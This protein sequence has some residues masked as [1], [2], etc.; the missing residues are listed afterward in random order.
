MLNAACVIAPGLNDEDKA[1]CNIFSSVTLLRNRIILTPFND[2][3]MMRLTAA[4]SFD[5]K[6]RRTLLSVAAILTAAAVPQAGIGGL[7][8]PGVSTTN[9]F[10]PGGIIPYEFDT[11]WPTTPAQRQTYLD[12]LREWELAANIRL[13]ARTSQTNYLRLRFAFQSTTN[14]FLLNP[15]EPPTLTVDSLQRNQLTHE[16]GHALGL[17]HEHVRA[18]RDGFIS[19]NTT[20]LDPNA[21]ALYAISSNAT[22]TGSYDFE[23]VMHYGRRLFAVDPNVDVITPKPAYFEKYYYRIGTLALSVGDRAAAAYLYGAPTNALTNV[24]TTTSDGGFG[25]L[26][27]AI[28][29]ANDHPGTTIRFNLSTNDPG[30]T[31]GVWTLQPTGEFPP[32]VADGT[33][34]DATTQ[35]G[36]TNH[37]IVALDGSTLLPE[38]YTSSGLHIYAAR[39]AVKGLAI[40]GFTY[41]GVL[42]EYSGATSNTLQGC[43]VGM[44]ATGMNPTPNLYH[45]ITLSLGANRNVIGGTN[46]L[47]RNVISGNLNYGILCSDTNTCGNVIQGNFIGLN[48][49]GDAVATNG[50]SGVGIVLGADTNTVG[51]GN[52]ISGNDYGVLIMDPNS[53]GNVV[54]GNFIGT[55][56]T[57]S[58]AL[59]NRYSGVGIFGQAK[60]TLVGGTNATARNVVSGNND[61]GVIVGDPGTDHTMIQGNYIG[62]DATGG[63]AVPNGT[64]IGLFRQSQFTTIGGDAPGAGNVI[65]G[66]TSDGVYIADPGTRSNFVAGNFI[67]TDRFG[68]NELPNQ[69]G[70]SIVAGPRF[71]LIGGTT[72][73]ARNVISGN[74]Y[75]AVYFAG[76][77]TASNAVTGNFIGTTANGHAALGNHAE[78][79]VLVAGAAFNVI[80]GDAAAARNVIAAGAYTGVYLAGAGTRGNV[81]QGNYIGTDATGTNALGHGNEGVAIFDGAQSNLIG[82]A[83][84]GE[85]NVI[86]ASAY[87][88]IF[89]ADTNTS[90]NLVQGNSIG[91]GADDTTP[92]PNGYE[93]V[94]IANGAGTNVIGL[95]LDGG[96]AGNRIAFNTFAGVY[97]GFY[98]EAG[99][100]GNVIR[101]NATYANGGLGIE[102]AGGTEDFNGVTANDGGDGDNGPNSLQNFPVITNAFCYPATTTIVGALNSTPNRAFL[103]DVYRNASADP[104]GYGEGQVYAGSAGLTTDGGGYGGFSLVNSG[105]LAGQVFTATA[106]DTITGDTSEFGPAMMATNAPP[107]PEFVAPVELTGTGFVASIS[108]A[109]GLNYRIQATTNLGT[110]PIPWMDLTN[111]VA[112]T[113]NYFFLDRGATNHPM[114]FYRVVSP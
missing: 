83:T 84:A 92:L 41:A 21:A 78:S 28:Y 108:L 88:G 42:L 25:S 33:V 18:D 100:R 11:N 99:T 96:G 90:G 51:P 113:T 114:R 107:P 75:N 61:Y 64:G 104:S 109:I 44:D 110:N 2:S 59:A 70:V 67:G 105:N 82:G 87:R 111:F 98:D 36:Y 30:Y 103:I 66:N 10:W 43:H 91:V 13:V 50:L 77:D 38:A 74:T 62:T 29:F 26:R 8:Y 35:P 93:G 47:Q 9:L 37:P 72:T 94:A 89:I 68:T 63:V 76:P 27:A 45:G 7:I 81:V 17:E 52:V 20:N 80:G 14:T 19:I 23:S 60:Y 1:A 6:A 40:G 55:D 79:I 49:A 106:T 48:A 112:G 73:A 56:A 85:G 34:I 31:N 46:A 24:V 4:F 5:H 69:V 3:V 54:A 71:N 12:G 15:P 53:D 57:G 86:G 97:V 95:A 39:C 58:V 32:L 22:M 16:M 65:S 102:L 101:G